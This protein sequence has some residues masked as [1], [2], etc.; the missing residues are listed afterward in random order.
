MASTSL[1]TSHTFALNAYTN[2]MSYTL[3]LYLFYTSWTW[4]VEMPSRS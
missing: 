4:R 3:L 1:S 2:S